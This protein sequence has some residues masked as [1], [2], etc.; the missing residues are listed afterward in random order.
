MTTNEIDEF[1]EEYSIP[2]TSDTPAH[3]IY[4]LDASGTMKENLDGRPR[5]RWLEEALEY[6]LDNMIDRS[7]KGTQVYRP[8]YRIAVITYSNDVDDSLTGGEFIDVKEFWDAGIP[9][10]QPNGQT[11][12]N[13]AFEYAYQLLVEL[14]KNS[15]VQ[16]ECPAP[17]VC[18]VTDG[19]YNVGGNP[20]P[21]VDK[22]KG[23]RNRDGFVLV[24]NLFISDNLL[25]SPISNVFSWS[26]LM[27]TDAKT[28]F[29]EGSKH[30]YAR[31]LFDM[32]SSLPDSY[33]SVLADEGFQLKPGSRMMYPGQNFDL[34]KLAF[35]ASMSTEF[36]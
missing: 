11:N 22:I 4:L 3:I 34:I 17:L 9:E 6:A 35:A 7:M 19:E 18:H 23:L 27:P 29:K 20:T 24:Q 15:N 31:A 10:L 33:A 8:R 26:G 36:R 28:A 12:T 5:A 32:S 2:A 30:K 14:L 21:T 1:H 13:A 16:E 25:N